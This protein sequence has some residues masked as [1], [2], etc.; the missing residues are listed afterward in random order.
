MLAAVL[1]GTVLVGC[2]Q[3]ASP[4]LS[5]LPSGIYVDRVGGRL[6]VPHYFIA[7]TNIGPDSFKG[8][9][10]S[11][12]QD[13][14]TTVV[15]TFTA[16]AQSG[17]ATL[18]VQASLNN[19]AGPPQAASL[20]SASYPRS[21]DERPNTAGGPPQSVGGA[22]PAGYNV[23]HSLTLENCDAYLSVTSRPDCD[24]VLSKG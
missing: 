4:L 21:L 12:G 2:G 16:T 3:S 14:S 19:G 24:F 1:T 15:F 10:D 18:T 11:V 6:D 13:G 9:L 17:V 20:L 7:L 23:H 5:I 22:W 8:T